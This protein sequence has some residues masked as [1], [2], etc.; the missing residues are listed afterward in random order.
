[1]TN[2]SSVDATTDLPS[3]SGGIANGASNPLSPLPLPSVS[4][5][6]LHHAVISSGPWPFKLWVWRR[7][8]RRPPSENE[9]GQKDVQVF[10]IRVARD[11]GM[12]AGRENQER[13]GGKMRT[14]HI[15]WRSGMGGGASID[16]AL[17]GTRDQFDQS[18]RGVTA[19]HLSVAGLEGGNF[20][21]RRG[22]RRPRCSTPASGDEWYGRRTRW[23][24]ADGKPPPPPAYR[25]SYRSHS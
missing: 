17:A 24:R 11:N 13:E 15:R 25:S 19:M 14:A 9:D 5:T 3:H 8:K 6:W 23:P 10:R 1:M 20:E 16:I 22:N 21:P 4:T 18:R 12:K 2:G 7:E